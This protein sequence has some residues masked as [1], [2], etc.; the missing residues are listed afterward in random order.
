MELCWKSLHLVASLRSLSYLSASVA[1]LILVHQSIFEFIALNV[2]RGVASIYLGERLD[3]KVCRRAVLSLH[4]KSAPWVGSHVVPT[5]TSR[6]G[7][8]DGKKEWLSGVATASQ[9]SFLSFLEDGF[10]RG[11]MWAISEDSLIGESLQYRRNQ[12]KGLEKKKR[13]KFNE[14]NDALNHVLFN[15]YRQPIIP[16]FVKTGPTRTAGSLWLRRLICA[17]CSLQIWNIFLLAP[18]QVKVR[19]NFQTLHTWLRSCHL[20]AAY[21]K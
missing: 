16:K 14:R 13:V 21:L 11:S 8:N 5:C 10:W 20:S 17:A 2:A 1:G 15:P 19:P 9:V 4:S 7:S 6:Q 12:F 3:F 18:K